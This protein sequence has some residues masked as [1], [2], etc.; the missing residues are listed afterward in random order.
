LII[1]SIIS[2]SSDILGSF[3]WVVM[4]GQDEANRAGVVRVGPMGGRERTG[5]PSARSGDGASRPLTGRAQAREDHF[6][7]IDDEHTLTGR[8]QARPLPHHAADILGAAA[9][10]A[11]Q[12]V[13]AVPDLP[14][15]GGVAV[16]GGINHDVIIVPALSGMSQ[17]LDQ[18]ETVHALSLGR[19]PEPCAA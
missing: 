11:H 19:A 15:D 16:S 7:L 5:G 2:A 13:T 3:G 8:H 4:N 10:T 14:H 17:E 6:R 18:F 12:V 1:C 9:S